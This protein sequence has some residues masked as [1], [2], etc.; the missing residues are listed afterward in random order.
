[1][2]QRK[3]IQVGGAQKFFIIGLSHTS[4][5]NHFRLTFAMKQHHHWSIEE[6]DQLVPWERDIYVTLLEQHI[7]EQNERM[8]EQQNG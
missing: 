8:R 7:K 6:M 3:Y 1:M 2:C 5:S 4:L